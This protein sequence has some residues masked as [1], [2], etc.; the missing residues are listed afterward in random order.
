MISRFTRAVWEAN[1]EFWGSRAAQHIKAGETHLAA[2]MA[3]YSGIL[4]A[5]SLGGPNA[6]RFFE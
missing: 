3:S 5:G 2:L 1:A 4:R 6:P